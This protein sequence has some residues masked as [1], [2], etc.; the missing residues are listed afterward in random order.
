MAQ[1]EDS[2]LYKQSSEDVRKTLDYL[3][4]AFKEI[5]PNE[6][7]REEFEINSDSED[8]WYSYVRVVECNSEEV[9]K[10][11]EKYIDFLSKKNYIDDFENKI[12]ARF[13]TGG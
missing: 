5:F 8:W 12:V 1:V 9:Q 7:V 10:L 6:P 2:E 11:N 3:K 4:V 13:E